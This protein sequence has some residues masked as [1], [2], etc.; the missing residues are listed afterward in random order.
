MIEQ[1]D[2]P[3]DAEVWVTSE[4]QPIQGRIITRTDNPRSYV[5]ETP[6]GELQ[7][8]STH[9]NVVPEQQTPTP[10]EQPQI[11]RPPTPPRRI[12]TRSQTGTAISPPDRLT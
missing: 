2:L 6:S 10:S 5:V 11:E 7:R 12:M 1:E 9:L 3:D 8:N 4:T